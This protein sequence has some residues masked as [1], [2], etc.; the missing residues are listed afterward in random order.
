MRILLIVFFFFFLLEPKQELTIIIIN[1]HQT[2]SSKKKKKKLYAKDKWYLI[3]KSNQSAV[4]VR[5]Y[6]MGDYSQNHVVEIGKD[7]Y[8]KRSMYACCKKYV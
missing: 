8:S 2:Y 5:I 4:L 7:I 6:R 3:Y 1:V